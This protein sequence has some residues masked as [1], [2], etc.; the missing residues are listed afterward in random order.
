[1]LM[2]YPSLFAA[3]GL[4]SSPCLF[5]QAASTLHPEKV[6]GNTTCAECHEEEVKAWTLSS[7]KRADSVHRDGYG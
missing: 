4:L 6:V 7:H 3:V 5:G 1:M 2:N